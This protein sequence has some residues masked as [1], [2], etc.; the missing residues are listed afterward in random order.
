LW[1][2]GGGRWWW[3]RRRRRRVV[4]V[5]MMMKLNEVCKISKNGYGKYVHSFNIQL[6]T[7]FDCG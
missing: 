4:V 3:R 1:G 6:F 7:P 2:C 5:I